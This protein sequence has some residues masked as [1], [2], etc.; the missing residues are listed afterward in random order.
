M[1]LLVLARD[2]LDLPPKLGY[3]RLVPARVGHGTLVLGV[4]RFEVA[5]G[6]V[7]LGLELVVAHLDPLVLLED[8]AEL[9]LELGLD[10][11]GGDLRG[12]EVLLVH[13]PEAL[14]VVLLRLAQAVHQL[15]GSS[16]LL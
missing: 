4:E 3:V 6:P 5:L 7:G 11:G 12:L 9:V 13:G 14:E 2:R 8:V 16:L 15:F 10:V 1:L